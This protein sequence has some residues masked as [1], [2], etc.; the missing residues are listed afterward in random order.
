MRIWLRLL[1]PRGSLTIRSDD[2]LPL[3][4]SYSLFEVIEKVIDD[5]KGMT[6]DRDGHKVCAAA[7]FSSIDTM[8]QICV[9][10]ISRQF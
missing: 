2:K 1:E 3:R 6:N 9:D 4:G 10:I 7:L 8:F 5:K